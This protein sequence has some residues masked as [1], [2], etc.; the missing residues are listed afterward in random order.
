MKNIFLIL[1]L[2]VSYGVYSQ[3]IAS[4]TTRWSTDKTIDISS[5]GITSELNTVVTYRS[6]SVTLS[7]D[8]GVIKYSFHVSEVTGNWDDGAGTGKV[9]YKIESNN[10]T[11]SV[12]L[13]NNKNRMRISFVLTIDGQLKL[14]DL[15]VDHFQILR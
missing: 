15:M 10:A 7:D 13:I 8:H 3:D 11:G 4:K 1:L 2:H 12:A 9:I 6:D 5:G 14:F